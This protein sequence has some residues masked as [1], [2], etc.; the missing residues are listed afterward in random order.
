[1]AG[2][3]LHVSMR[4]VESILTQKPSL[5]QHQQCTIIKTLATFIYFD[6]DGDLL[7]AH[8]SQTLPH[9][10]KQ[11]KQL[12]RSGA[13]SIIGSPKNIAREQRLK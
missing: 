2:K 9:G 11:C 5:K 3:R 6:G 12:I 4:A 8:K 10:G 1:M 13:S 7:A